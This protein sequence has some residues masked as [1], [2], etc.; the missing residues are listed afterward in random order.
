[1]TEPNFHHFHLLVNSQA[2]EL[3]ADRNNISNFNDIKVKWVLYETRKII[4]ENI[5]PLA[6]EGYFR[7]RKA[8]KLRYDMF[9]L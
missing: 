6:N 2:F 7:L 9:R 5:I 8:E 1:M 4:N 3:T